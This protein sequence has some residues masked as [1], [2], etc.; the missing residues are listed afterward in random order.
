MSF[1]VTWSLSRSYADPTL[2]HLQVSVCVRYY[3]SLQHLDGGETQCMKIKFNSAV[4]FHPQ[5]RY[6]IRSFTCL[7]NLDFII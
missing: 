1:E 7:S 6:I 3:R 4:I 2:T 5:P